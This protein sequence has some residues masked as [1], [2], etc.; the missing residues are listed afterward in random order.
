M[1]GIAVAQHFALSLA[2]RRFDHVG[3]N[4]DFL[5]VILVRKIL[6]KNYCGMG[7]IRA[8]G[9]AADAPSENRCRVGGVCWIHAILRS[10]WNRSAWEGWI[11]A[12][13]VGVQKRPSEST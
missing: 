5:R 12:Q 4:R 1:T 11:V 10:R 6:R 8:T 2:V 3:V 7:R 13:W 9:Y